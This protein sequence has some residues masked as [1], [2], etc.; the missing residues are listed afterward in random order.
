M[1]CIGP[2]LRLGSVLDPQLSALSTVSES[3]NPRGPEGRCPKARGTCRPILFGGCSFAQGTSLPKEKV[4]ALPRPT[5]VSEDQLHLKQTLALCLQKL[6]IGRYL[7]RYAGR[8]A[9]GGSDEEGLKD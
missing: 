4:S 2:A 5:L 3:P 6:F 7:Q 1:A 8:E 9:Q